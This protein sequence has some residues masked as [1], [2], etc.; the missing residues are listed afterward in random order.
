MCG[1]EETET[2]QAVCSA[3]ALQD[4][5]SH[6][7]GASSEK[8]ATARSVVV[9]VRRTIWQNAHQLG[10][11]AMQAKPTAAHAKYQSFARLQHDDGPPFAETERPKPICLSA[12]DT[13]G[14]E[15]RAPPAS[16]SS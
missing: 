3:Q 10:D 14:S 1:R 11:V 16:D 7:H 6:A 12:I 5:V 9:G 4:I 15:T 13:K 8:A 2:G